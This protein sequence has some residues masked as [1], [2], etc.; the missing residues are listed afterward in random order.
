[1]TPADFFRLADRLA[2]LEPEARSL[3]VEMLTPPGP[4]AVDTRRSAAILRRY[5][6]GDTP[7]PAWFAAAVFVQALRDAG[8]VALEHR[9]RTVTAYLE[10]AR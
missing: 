1:M 10:A 7:P 6:A 9:P 2:E 8:V 4:G 3:A 5:R